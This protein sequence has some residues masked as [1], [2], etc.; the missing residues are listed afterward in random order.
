MEYS[1]L[2]FIFQ[3]LPFFLLF[4]WLVKKPARNVVL[5]IASLFFY[6]WG[7]GFFVLFL[8]TA[9]L[10]NYL[11]GL[12]IKK[13]LSG[14]KPYGI[15]LLA[16]AANI[17][18]LVFFKY[19]HFLAD[20]LNPLLEWIGLP[21]ISLSP[22]HLPIGISFITFQAISYIVDIYRQRAPAETSIL[23]FSVYL[24]SFPKLV[25]GPI[26]P[27]HQ[28]V[29]QLGE[30]RVSLDD[31]S[32]GIKRFILGL[33]KKVL[34]ADKLAPVA[35]Q[36]FS[37]PA[38]SQTAGLAWLGI[39]GFTLQIYFDFSGYSDMAIGV[40]RMCGFKLPENF[41]YPYMASSIK[42]FWR[43]WHMSLA[44]WL[45]DY[46]FLPIAYSVSR[47]IKSDRFLGIRAEDWSYHAGSFFTMVLC[48]LW[49]GANWTFVLWGTFY[50]IMLVVEHAGLG[51][52]IKRFPKPIRIIY[53]QLLVVMAWVFFRSD[54][55]AYAWKFL[56]AM[57]GFG[58]GNGIDYYPAL[59][60]NPEV[61][62]ILGIGLAG[63]FPLLSK[64]GSAAIPGHRKPWL[65]SGFEAVSQL[66]LLVIFA[67]SIMAL[68]SGSYT[69]FI[70]F[71]F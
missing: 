8:A 16:L 29:P 71:R 59:F 53:T 52:R 15:F 67:L 37:I 13:R 20:N 22:I 4:F 48:G 40:G 10:V 24:G 39:I 26:S 49:H 60:L 65:R 18:A 56:K 2:I 44:T 9:I 25:M 69:P 51:K 66:L 43:R 19:T 57:F 42:D 1:S 55:L 38:E 64:L 11:F 35:S 17:G 70:Y 34:V 45:R 41:N 36:I 62:V 54:T 58:T 63:S 28:L 46:L 30:R 33:G 32:R 61:M 68:A 5:L 14:R 3:F 50:G 23:R 7:E 27:Y 6:F 12:W 21:A 47:R 31:F